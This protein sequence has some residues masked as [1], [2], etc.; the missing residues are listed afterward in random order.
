MHTTFFFWNVCCWAA[1]VG[2]A[3]S[4]NCM[5]LQTVRMLIVS[6]CRSNSTLSDG[7]LTKPHLLLAPRRR[8]DIGSLQT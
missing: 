6:L 4:S 5:K 7:R 3:G 8:F 1:G 2:S